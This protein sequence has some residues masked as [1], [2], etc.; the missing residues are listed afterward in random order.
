[1]PWP[2]WSLVLY[3]RW[4]G[5]GLLPGRRIPSPRAVVVGVPSFMIVAS[6]RGEPPDG[7]KPGGKAGGGGLRLLWCLR[8]PSMTSSSSQLLVHRG[9]R[10]RAL[11]LVQRQTPRVFMGGRGRCLWG[12]P[13]GGRLVDRARAG[14]AAHRI[15]FVQRHCPSS[16]RSV[17]P[18]TGGRRL[19]GCVRCTTIS[20]CWAWSEVRWRRG[21]V[22]ASAGMLG[23]A[24]AF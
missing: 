18:L 23:V 19:F 14:A 1:L 6:Q 15:V 13:L 5:P 16:C 8:P 21:L 12:R 2:A 9:G 17:L 3:W 22:M 10:R 20:S 24:L 7:W 11:P 4:L